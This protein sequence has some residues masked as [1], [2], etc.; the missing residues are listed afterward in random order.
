M[1]Y[2][3]RLAALIDWPF[4]S[5]LSLITDGLVLD[6]TDVDSCL[7]IAARATSDLLEPYL[8]SSVTS[9]T[10]TFNHP[11][12]TQIKQNFMRIGLQTK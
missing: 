12:C 7:D 10:S 11:Q 5:K 6:V 3:R 1:G 9:M 2:A 8:A 4:L